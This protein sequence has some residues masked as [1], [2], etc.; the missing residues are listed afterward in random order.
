MKW[1]KNA[2]KKKKWRFWPISPQ[3]TK[4]PDVLCKFWRRNCIQRKKMFGICITVVRKNDII[5]LLTIL[6][7]LSY[8]MRRLFLSLT[9]CYSKSFN[10]TRYRSIILKV[11]NSNICK[12]KSETDICKRFP[13]KQTHL[14]Q[15]V[16]THN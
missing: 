9:L 13:V 14:A 10:E 15:N 2:K 11:L 3:F 4:N 12:S 7:L 8:F 5:N 1:V 6:L 16:R